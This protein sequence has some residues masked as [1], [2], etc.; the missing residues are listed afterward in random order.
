[1]NLTFPRYRFIMISVA[2]SIFFSFLSI[3][4]LFAFQA[5]FAQ[6]GADE[7]KILETQLSELEA[8]IVQ[9]ENTI[10][11]LKTQ[12]KSL[13]S[14]IGRLNAKIDKINLQIKAV[15]LRLSQL[16]KDI[17]EKEVLIQDTEEKIDF[18]KDALSQ[19]LRRI[20]ADSRSG[21]MEI[22]LRNPKLSDFFGDL[23]NLIDVQGGLALTIDKITDL[24]NTLVDEKEVLSLKRNDA[25]ALKTYQDSQKS[26]LQGTKGEKANLLAVT[27]GKEVKFSELLKETQKT[28]AQ[29]RSRI[30]QL[31]GGGELTFEQAYQFA[32]L[33]EQATGVRAALILAVLDKESALG[34]NV[35][36]CSYKTSMHPT[37]DIPFFLQ[38]TGELS[39]NPESITVSCANRDGAYGG[40]MGPAQFIPST[41]NLYKA[42]IASVTGSNPPSPW[43]HADAFVGTALYLKDAGAANAG[44]SKEREAAARYYAGSRWRTHLWTYGDRVITKAQKFQEDIDTLNA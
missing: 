4:F 31:L 33:A 35:G 30:F 2:K 23:N 21:L 24:K 3:A 28:A 44:L 19:G 1:M 27:K 38:I 18:N 12:G 7:R 37:R 32:K 13:Q 6:T 40:A 15:N 41:W 26:E 5:V 20:Y 25:A 17:S 36:R 11:G 10:Q 43:K 34:Q 14:E 22:L 16:D 8:Q 29:I 9:H 42:Q 39:I